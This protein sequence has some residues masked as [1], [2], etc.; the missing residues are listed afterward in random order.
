MN[1][2]KCRQLVYERSEQFCERCCRNGPYLSVHHRL[3]K[4]QGGKWTPTNCVLLCGTGTS[5]CHQ[6]CE[7]Y[8]NAAEVEGFHVRPWNNPDD[9]AVHWR[10]QKWV[11]LLDDG[12]MKD[13]HDST[14]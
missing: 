7:E 11:K 13:W 1:E 10:K 12:S 9:I 6:F 4:G 5:G 14:G 2:R 3:K 8:P